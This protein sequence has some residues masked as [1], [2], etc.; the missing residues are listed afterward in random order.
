[1]PDGSNSLATLFV[2]QIL[3]GEPKSVFPA[4]IAQAPYRYPA[5]FK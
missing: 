2:S 5:A 4:D 1:M 3:D